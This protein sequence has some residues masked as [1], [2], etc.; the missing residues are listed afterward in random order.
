VD[1]GYLKEIQPGLI[2]TSGKAKLRLTDVCRA[3][4][5]NL[6]LKSYTQLVFRNG[7]IQVTYTEKT[8]HLA[9]MPAHKYSFLKFKYQML[10]VQPLL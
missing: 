3:D 10:L 4:V 5:I 2:H 1:C 6:V 9:S 8:L 7:D